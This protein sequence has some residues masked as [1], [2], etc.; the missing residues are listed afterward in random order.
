MKFIFDDP[1]FSYE[2]LRTIGYS[3]TGGADIGE[4]VNTAYRIEEGNFE[5]WFS[6]WNALAK[7]VEL[8][9][10]EFKKHGQKISASE[11]Y[12]KASN[13]Y[14]SA[15][16]F[17]H[18]D[19]TDSR[20]LTTWKKS[21]DT[22][23]TG[24]K[25]ASVNVEF[26]DIPFG[27]TSMPGYFYKVDDQARPTLIVHGGYDSTGEELFFQVA[28][29]ALKHG[30]N[31][32]T[33]EGPGQGAVIREQHLPFR[34]DWENVVG[35]VIDYLATRNDV[36]Q[37]KIALMG[38]SFGGLLAPRAA[39]FDKRIA[40]VIADDGVYSFSF[41]DAFAARG[42]DH[43][44]QAFI[45]SKMKELMK[46]STNVRWVIENGMFTFGASSV[47]DLFDKTVAFK[48]D[49]VADKIECPILIG[50][51]ANDGFFKGQPQMLYDAVNAP[52]TLIKFGPDDGAEEHCQ[53]GGITYYNQRVFEWLDGVFK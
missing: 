21:R 12:L 40:A 50:E 5:S 13:Y 32:L 46:V 42:H 8:K 24:I 23:R 33:F 35:P 6:E 36:D 29:D 48:L 44:D 2:T 34:V 52:K 31:V 4:V 9:A 14:R 7:R 27:E 19:P 39:A 16:F 10:D 3:V 49:Q 1:T 37:S 11:N 45:E 17:L 22:F 20:M 26:I 30:Y 18:G 43:P 28:S 53:M 25:M 47:S 41:T 15:E 38:I 51:A